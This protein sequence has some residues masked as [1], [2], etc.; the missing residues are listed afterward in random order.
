MSSSPRLVPLLTLHS[1]GKKMSKSLKN[2]PDPNLIIDSYGADALRL[3]LINS[4]VVRG[5]SLRFREEGVKE[6]ISRVLLPF[7]NSYRFFLGQT[8]L[9]K[10][11]S[12][13]DFKYDPHANASSNVM[14]QWVLAR[15]QSLIQTVEEEMKGEHL[16]SAGRC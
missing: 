16:R 8:T 12:G 4:P 5:D 13:I 3:F 9:L 14:D 15:C 1:D 6:T 11:E 10:K 7:L 2:Y